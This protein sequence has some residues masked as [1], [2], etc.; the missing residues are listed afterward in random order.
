VLV[1]FVFLLSTTSVPAQVDLFKTRFVADLKVLASAPDAVVGVAVKDLLSGEEFVING[2]EV[3]PL[4]SVIK[5]PILAEL[6]RQAEQGELRLSDVVPVPA[7]ARAGGGP[8]LNELGAASVSM[9]LRDYAI[10][11]I[12]LSDNTATNLLIDRVGMENVNRFLQSVG[13]KSTRLQRVMMDLKAATEGRE[14]V[15]TPRDVMS[16]LEKMHHGDLVSKSSSA[17]MLSILR[18]PKEGPLRS[19]IPEAV[20]LADKRGELDGVKCNVGIVFLKDAPYVICVMTKLLQN[21]EDGPKTITAISRLTYQYFE[22]KINSNQYGRRL[23]R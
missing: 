21:E 17:D 3:F 6:Y 8:I 5:I 13:A 11:M 22:R 18:K 15:G 19:G 23:R 12:V 10:L 20:D 1:V 7:S 14:N 9:S 4:A 16:L 2:D